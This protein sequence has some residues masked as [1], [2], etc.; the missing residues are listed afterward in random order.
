[1]LLADGLLR[2][3]S[4]HDDTEVAAQPFLENVQA[5]THRQYVRELNL[6]KVHR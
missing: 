6:I 2:L 4:L 1:M 5:E 3:Q